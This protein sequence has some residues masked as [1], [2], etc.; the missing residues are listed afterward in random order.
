[1]CLKRRAHRN[2][3]FNRTRKNTFSLLYDFL[4]LYVT[5]CLKRGTHRNNRLNRTGN[6]TF[7]LLYDFLNSYVTMCLENTQILEVITASK[8]E[9]PELK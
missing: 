6:N 9:T 3:R 8:G 1:M 7:S 2:N 5:V 4:N